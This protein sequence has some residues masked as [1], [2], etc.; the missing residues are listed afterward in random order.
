MKN[1]KVLLVFITLFVCG[2]STFAQSKKE[3]KKKQHLEEYEAIKTLVEEGRLVFKVTTMTPYQGSNTVVI[4]DGVLIEENFLHVNLP[5]MGNFHAGYTPSNSSNIE[6][7]TDDTIFEV[8]YN[9]KK[10]KLKINF[11]V[12]HNTE[13]FTFNMAIYRNGRTNLQVVSNLRSRMVYD[14]TVESTPQI[15]DN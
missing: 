4:G 10:Q 7:S 2:Q 14:G 5:F 1:Y 6:F 9:D 11:E 12:V 8:I 15:A 13:V 3:L